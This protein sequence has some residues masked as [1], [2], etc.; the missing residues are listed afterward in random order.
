MGVSWAELFAI[1]VGLS[2]DA[3]AISVCKGLALGKVKIRHMLIPALW[4]GAFQALMPLLGWLV[5]SR[6]E[7]LISTA[8]PW[9]AFVL[10]AIIG[11]NM[12]RE[13]I[14]GHEESADAG[15]SVRTMLPLA[16]ATSIDALV[17][18][19]AFAAMEASAGAVKGP[20][21]IQVAVISIGLTSFVISA[22]GML[23]GSFAGARLGKHAKLA[24]GVILVLIGL[25][26]LIEHLAA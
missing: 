13:S 25:K 2:M 22:A 6:F 10:L 4:F 18:G 9:I 15:L 8:A 7:R 12:I 21:S 20:Q 3:F 23:T 11:A 5:G 26:I 14:S 24:G 16:V 1:A 19:V 17:T